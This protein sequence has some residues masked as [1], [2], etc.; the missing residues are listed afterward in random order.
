MTDEARSVPYDAADYL[1]SPEDIAAYLEAVIEEG[2]ERA[3]LSALRDAA[4]A[5]RR[6]MPLEIPGLREEEGE[7]SFDSLV[8]LLHV[9]GFEFSLR[10]KRA[11]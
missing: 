11:A 3:L 1:E 9:L 4:R 6:V 8:A 7:P 2:D 5:A 10:P